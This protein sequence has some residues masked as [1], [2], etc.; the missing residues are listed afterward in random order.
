MTKFVHGELSTHHLMTRLIRQFPC[1]APQ[2]ASDIVEKAE[3]VFLWV[4]LVV[5]LLIEGLENG[6]NLDE[7]ETR[8][9]AL[10]SDLKALYERMFGKMSIEYQK[11]ASLLF[12]LKEK[13]LSLVTDRPL[14]ALVLWHA[15]NSPL[16]VFDQPTAPMA[17]ETY[18]WNMDSLVKRIQSRCC[19]L[20]E[21]RYVGK[22]L[23]G[24][25]SIITAGECVSIEKMEILVVT[26]LHRTV[27]EFLTVQEV[28][29][30]ICRLTNGDEHNMPTRL[31]SAALSTLK[32]ANQITGPTH[33]W[34][35]TLTTQLCR[36]VMDS[37][38]EMAHRFVLEMDRTMTDLLDKSKVDR[39]HH[40]YFTSQCLRHWSTESHSLR[41]ADS[42]GLILEC[43]APGSLNYASIYTYAAGQ[44]L[45]CQP[46]VVP[47]EL[48]DDVR[49]QI[50][51]H[52]LSSWQMNTSYTLSLECRSTTMT[53]L[54]GNVI[55]PETE[56]YNTSL[57]EMAL[58]VC[59]KLIHD[60]RYPEAARLLEIFLS[61][62]ESP[63]TLWKQPVRLPSYIVDAPEALLRSLRVYQHRSSLR[64][65]ANLV[66]KIERLA[67]VEKV[68]MT[69]EQV[70]HAL[71]RD[72][73]HY[74]NKKKKNRR[75]NKVEKSRAR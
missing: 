28:W 43:L 67:R 11:Q 66:D 69:P 45:F 15:I 48:N 16:A 1:K 25:S 30:D 75:S 63:W 57:W 17:C 13:W 49:F 32:L 55:R 9:T 31:A 5:R 72:N 7:L 20:L 74:R 23:D 41:S 46:M 53:Y 65:D 4:K 50:V 44:G 24:L 61:K 62:T 73:H 36:E 39:Y 42:Y 58:V 54:L 70:G 52:A 18:D 59:K 33:D 40:S 37:S 12:Q 14:P 26:Y 56:G 38:P 21:L 27:H 34:Y 6:D 19:G 2:L 47:V 8:L 22:T 51:L 60:G 3:G 64:E 10:P 29:Q 35:L 68:R 71:H